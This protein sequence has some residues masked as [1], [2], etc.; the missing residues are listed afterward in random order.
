MDKRIRIVWLLS[1]VT[2][3]LIFVIRALALKYH[4]GVPVL[5]GHGATFHHSKKKPGARQVDKRNL[6]LTSKKEEA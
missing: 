4:L 3:A 2:M 1:I 6:K 5:T